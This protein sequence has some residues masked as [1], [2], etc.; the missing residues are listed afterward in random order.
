MLDGTRVK[1]PKDIANDY[2]SS[3]DN[4]TN[5][6]FSA[7]NA[8]S[9]FRTTNCTLFD[10]YYILSNLGSGKNLSSLF[11]YPQN[12]D[13]GFFDIETNNNPD[14][15]LFADCSQ[16]TSL[17]SCFGRNA[18]SKRIYLKSPTVEDGI[19]TIDNGLF[20]SLTSCTNFTEIFYTYKYVV[21]KYLFRRKNGNYPI[22]SLSYFTPTHILNEPPLDYS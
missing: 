9:T 11:E 14:I 16:V 7:T 13:Y 5:I 8:S 20:S 10:Y 3:G 15:R 18:S 2:F 12:T 17:S 19:V 22:A 4:V 6:T 21:D 1:H